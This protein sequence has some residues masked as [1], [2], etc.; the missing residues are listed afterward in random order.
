MRARA[1]VCVCVCEHAA[2][3]MI[4]KQT[5]KCKQQPYKHS[6]HSTQG[7][8]GFDTAYHAIRCDFTRVGDKYRMLENRAGGHALGDRHASGATRRGSVPRVGELG[9][10]E[11]MPEWPQRWPSGP[12]VS[13]PTVRT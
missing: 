11:T 5:T 7:V 1:R 4:L 3:A 9:V 12:P 6:G 8:L 10:C 13:C 2:F